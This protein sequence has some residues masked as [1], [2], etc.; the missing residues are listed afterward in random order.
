MNAIPVVERRK[1][2]HS[3]TGPDSGPVIYSLAIDR[4]C[5][6]IQPMT[7]V[8]FGKINNSVVAKRMSPA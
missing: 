8:R 6:L 4:T 3:R 1:D 5:R 2:W 7:L